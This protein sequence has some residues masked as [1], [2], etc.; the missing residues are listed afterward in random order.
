LVVGVG[1]DIVDLE[2]F[3]RKL[4]DAL[5]AELFLPGEVEYASSRARPWESY[6]VRLAAKEACF[7]A[8]GAGLSQGM[9]WGDVEVV[10]GPEGD[11]GIVLSGAALAVAGR[12]GV[13]SSRLSM[14]HS[15]KSAVAVVVLES[16]A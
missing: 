6:A 10:R 11:V 16:E 5:V 9:R 13:S 4:D 14:S 7:K 8:L 2:E 3:R 12:L 1:I 15:R